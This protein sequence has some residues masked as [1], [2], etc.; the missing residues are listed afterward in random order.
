V[1]TFETAFASVYHTVPVPTFETAFASVY[2]TVPY[3]S[4][5]LLGMCHRYEWGMARVP[6]SP[7]SQVPTTRQAPLRHQCRCLECVGVRLF[8]MGCFT[9]RGEVFSSQVSVFSA[10]DTSF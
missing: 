5:R 2:H 1:P 4:S 9:R 6:T 10:Y 7:D 3:P 8:S